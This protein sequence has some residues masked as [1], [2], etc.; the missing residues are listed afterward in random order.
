M[1]GWRT[2]VVNYW[3]IDLVKIS[4]HKVPWRTSAI[5]FSTPSRREGQ[6]TCQ[7]AINWSALTTDYLLLNTLS[8]QRYHTVMCLNF[9]GLDITTRCVGLVD[10]WNRRNLANNRI[11]KSFPS[12]WR[13]K[14]VVLN[15][16]YSDKDSKF[17]LQQHRSLCEGEIVNDKDI[18]GDILAGVTT[19]LA[20]RQANI[21][22]NSPTEQTALTPA[23]TNTNGNSGNIAVVLYSLSELILTVGFQQTKL[24]IRRLTEV[25]QHQQAGTTATTATT[26]TTSSSASVTLASASGNGSNSAS[27]AP[28]LILSVHQSLH[29]AEVNAQLQALASVLVR[30]VPNSGTLAETV[31][32]EIQTVRR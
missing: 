1:S 14:F 7:G 19:S 25:L 30:V 27:H 17:H 3:K 11:A 13:Q 9:E 5:S 21:A 23:A 15:G 8:N 20:T 10:S 2:V 16:Q 4:S 26:S 6:A 29:S 22:P 24:F 32:A 31:A 18:W 28:C 12:D